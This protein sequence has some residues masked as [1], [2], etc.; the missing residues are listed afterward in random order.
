MD[1]LVDRRISVKDGALRFSVANQ[2]ITMGSPY[3][4]FQAGNAKNL[5]ALP[6]A[7]GD[8][9]LF[10]AFNRVISGRLDR[11]GTGVRRVVM[12]TEAQ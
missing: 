5:I 7:G 8:M 4:V 1:K 6:G 10:A 2:E 11:T 12:S 9:R 3:E